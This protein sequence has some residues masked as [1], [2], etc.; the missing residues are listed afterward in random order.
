MTNEQIDQM[1][2]AV[3]E[4]LKDAGVVGQEADQKLVDSTKL[5]MLEASQDLRVNMPLLK[6]KKKTCKRILKC[7]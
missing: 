5:G 3:L 6:G 1:K 7:L 2:V 4:V